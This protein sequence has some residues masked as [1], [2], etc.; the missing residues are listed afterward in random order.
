MKITVWEF[1]AGNPRDGEKEDGE[2]RIL[3]TSAGSGVLDGTSGQI[4]V[5]LDFYIE[6]HKNSFREL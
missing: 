6:N 4:P 2:G 3:V 1:E 5:Q